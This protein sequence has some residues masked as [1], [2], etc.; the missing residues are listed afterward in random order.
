MIFHGTL[1][2]P[3]RPRAWPPP[4]WRLDTKSELIIW[5][6][7]PTP[8][9]LSVLG[10]GQGLVDVGDDVVDVLDAD[11]EPHVAVGYTGR[12]LILG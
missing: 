5:I 1:T 9:A 6:R 2:G 8:L 12:Q 3:A 4:Q 10:F 11:R 7:Y